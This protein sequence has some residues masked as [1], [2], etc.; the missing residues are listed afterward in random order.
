MRR[1]ELGETKSESTYNKKAFFT[2]SIDDNENCSASRTC[3]R[4]YGSGHDRRNLDSRG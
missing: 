4:A 2:L 3:A 1:S